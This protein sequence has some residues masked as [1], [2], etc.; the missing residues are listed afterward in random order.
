M[1]KY[2]FILALVFGVAS[3]AQEG[4]KQFNPEE[5][6]K[7]L[8]EQIT[9]YLQITDEGTIQAVQREAY[10]Y[11]LSM[12]K[13]LLLAEQEGLFRQ[14]KDLET[15]MRE[16]KPEVLKATKFYDQ[17]ARILGKDRVEKLREIDLF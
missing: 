14:G 4:A 17:L 6:A 7:K 16:I 10:Y 9:G 11:A 3:Y 5:Y 13:H 1:K 8:T 12:Q 15:V 2:L